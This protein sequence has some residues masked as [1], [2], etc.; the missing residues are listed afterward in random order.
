MVSASDEITAVAVFPVE[1]LSGGSVPADQVR[2]FLIERLTAAGIRVL[3]DDALDEFIARHRVRY[4][5]GIDAATAELLRQDTGVGGVVIASVEMSSEAVPPKIALHARLVS[6]RSAPAVV[7]ADDAGLSGD[8]ALG[9]FG[10]SVVNDYQKL[11]TSALSH[12]TDSLLTYLKAGEAKPGPKAESKFRPKSSYR[13]QAIQPGKAYTI[14]VLPFFNLSERRNAGD[15]LALHFI[16]HLSGVQQF[17]VIDAGVTR[18]QLLDARVIMDGGISLSDAETVAALIDADLVLGGRVLRY[19]DYEGPA[20]RT[21]VEFSTVLIERQ[22]R[23]VVWSSDSYNEGSDGVWFFE[24]GTSR[25]AHAMATQMVR[26]TTEM[27]AGRD[28]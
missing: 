9:L 14:A 8:D 1:N 7:W 23:R 27:I 16:R 25:T 21:R 11:L 24:R 10:M 18:R 15:I 13:S 22:S 19:E 2:R 12:V 3:E 28:R 26:L 17:H 4:A 5:A 6:I 20:G